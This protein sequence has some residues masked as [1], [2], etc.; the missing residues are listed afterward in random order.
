M[1]LVDSMLRKL[2]RCLLNDG[3][4]QCPPLFLD[5]TVCRGTVTFLE[6]STIEATQH[7]LCGDDTVLTAN[8]HNTNF[9]RTN[10]EGLTYIGVNL[11][12]NVFKGTGLKGI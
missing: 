3:H 1:P 5:S 11:H 2:L 8:S 10:V 7:S 6:A 4:E 12:K 9:S